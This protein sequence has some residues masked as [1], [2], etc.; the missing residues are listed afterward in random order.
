M[1]R[2]KPACQV[3]GNDSRDLLKDAVVSLLDLVG[4]DQVQRDLIHCVRNLADELDLQEQQL[5]DDD[6]F[7]SVEHCAT[8]V[9]EHCQLF[10]E[11]TKSR[12]EKVHGLVRKLESVSRVS[13]VSREMDSVRT[14]L[15]PCRSFAASYRLQREC[16]EKIVEEIVSFLSDLYVCNSFLDMN[17]TN[18]NGTSTSRVPTSGKLRQWIECLVANQMLLKDT[19]WIKALLQDLPTSSGRAEPKSLQMASKHDK[20]GD[21]HH[22]NGK[23]LLETTSDLQQSRNSFLLEQQDVMG[24]VDFF[25]AGG[26]HDLKSTFILLVGP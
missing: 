1:G 3:E 25:L 12:S 14:V 5:Q 18:T 11:T 24:A 21:E 8:L 19:Q 16:D 7:L 15:L 17:E 9:R 13:A 26:A 22:P 2:R 23:S 4:T 10:L 6:W 20:D